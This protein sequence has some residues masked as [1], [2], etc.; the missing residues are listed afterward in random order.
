MKFE[1]LELQ[2]LSFSIRSTFVK[3]ESILVRGQAVHYLLSLSSV[4][5]FLALYKNQIFA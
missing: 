5:Y 3:C 1:A 2:A 4:Q